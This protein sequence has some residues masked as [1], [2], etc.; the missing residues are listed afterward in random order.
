MDAPTAESVADLSAEGIDERGLAC[1]CLPRH[2]H[3]STLA[4]SR[5][6][7]ELHELREEAVALEQRRC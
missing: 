2:E 5:L 4:P 6:A 3:D 7:L 1:T